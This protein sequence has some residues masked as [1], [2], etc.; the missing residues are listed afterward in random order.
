M[1]SGKNAAGVWSAAGTNVDRSAILRSWLSTDPGTD[2]KSVVF[3][4]L[5]LLRSR[6]AQLKED[7]PADTKHH[8]AIK[9]NPL[10]AVLRLV[11]AEGVGLEAASIEEVHLAKESGC[12]G[13]DVAYDSPAKTVEEIRQALA[14]G[15]VLS[16]DNLDELGRVVRLDSDSD[17]VVLL[18]ISPEVADGDVPATSVGGADSRFGV[19]W[20][21]LRAMTTT[22][23]RDLLSTVDGLHVHTGSQGISMATQFESLGRIMSM[24]MEWRAEFRRPHDVHLNVGGGAPA[25]VRG[26]P[27][28]FTPTD[29]GLFL[30]DSIAVQRSRLTLHTEFGRAVMND[31]AFAASKVEYVRSAPNGRKQLVSHLGADMFMRAAYAPDYWPLDIEVLIGGSDSKPTEA[32]DIYGPL[33]FAGDRIGNG[34][35]MGRVVPGDWLGFLGVGG[36]TLGLWSRHCSRAMPPVV[37]F[38]RRETGISFRPLRRAESPQDLVRFWS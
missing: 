26:T 33:C 31:S 29:V 34:V 17:A 15:C 37:G 9:A 4:D 10:L 12:S 6:L 20:S 19:P 13:G 24:V 11:V 3:Y 2:T 8:V 21:A 30:R 16:V 35:E 25:A 14:W 32:Y 18:R 28:A 5:D 23:R 27:P 36:Y 38:E 7:F 1:G 22:D